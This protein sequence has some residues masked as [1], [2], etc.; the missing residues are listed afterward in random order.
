MPPAPPLTQIIGRTE[1]ALRPLMDRVLAGTGGTFPQWVALT[2]TAG[3]ADGIERP[4]LIARVAGA[5]QVDGTAADAVIGEL[6]DEQL[7][8]ESGS[9]SVV[10]LSDAGRERHAAIRDAIDQITAQ[11]FAAIP[12]DDEAATRRVLTTIAERAEAQLAAPDTVAERV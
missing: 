7:L 2:L 3:N 4:E 1:R 12:A 6:A 11:L 5:L 9:E 8:Q 10:A